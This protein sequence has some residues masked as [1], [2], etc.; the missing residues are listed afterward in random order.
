M[1]VGYCKDP[2]QV[3]Q[4]AKF[5]EPDLYD[6]SKI[7]G[8][9]RRVLSDSDCRVAD[10]AIGRLGQIVRGWYAAE[11]PAGQIVF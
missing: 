6:R 4:N 5:T 1:G 9:V 8:D 2:S 11:N 7:P 3:L 10:K